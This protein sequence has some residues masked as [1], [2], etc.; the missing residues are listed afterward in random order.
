MGFVAVGESGSNTLL[1]VGIGSVSEVEE[2]SRHLAQ[3]GGREGRDAAL[4]F[5]DVHGVQNNGW[6]DSGQAC[7][8]A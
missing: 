7:E 6:F 1:I 5:F 8:V 4:D 3:F 2:E